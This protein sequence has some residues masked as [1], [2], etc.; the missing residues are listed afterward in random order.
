MTAAMASITSPNIGPSRY[1]RFSFEAELSDSSPAGQTEAVRRT[2]SPHGCQNRGV[3]V[4]T[5]EPGDLKQK[6]CLECGSDSGVITG[7]AYADGDAN[8]V[9][10]VG[11]CEGDHDPRRA[12]LTIS[13]GEWGEGTDAEDRINVCI[14]WREAGM[15][16]SEE[17]V[18]SRPDLLGRFVSRNEAMRLG[19]VEALWHLADHI[20][21]DDPNVRKVSAWLHG[22]S[23]TALP[24]G[25]SDGPAA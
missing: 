5:V 19:G 24:K 10:Y 18:M 12:F 14:E 25:D 17:P 4:I 11:W 13:P 2:A 23:P 9:Y 8:S 21:V 7:F 15:R 16:L 6:P 1:V 3:P 20:V 22:E